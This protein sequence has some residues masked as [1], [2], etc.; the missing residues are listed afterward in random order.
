MR[1]TLL[2]LSSSYYLF[3][4]VIWLVYFLFIEHSKKHEEFKRF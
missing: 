1:G 3:V 2:T 4:L